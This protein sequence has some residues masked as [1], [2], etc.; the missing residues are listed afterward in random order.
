[1]ATKEKQGK[2]E[3]PLNRYEV[4]EGFHVEQRFGDNDEIT[5]VTHTKGKIVKSR[6][7]LDKIVRQQ[8][9]QPGQ[10]DGSSEGGPHRA[11]HDGPE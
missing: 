7:P 11:G 2:K 5:H 4:L 6:K 1:M 9:S 3:A 8:V 10:A